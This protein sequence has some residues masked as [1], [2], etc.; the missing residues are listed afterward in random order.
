LSKHPFTRECYTTLTQL[1][2]FTARYK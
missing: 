1:L 2:I